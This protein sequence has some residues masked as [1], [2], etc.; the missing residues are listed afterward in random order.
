MNNNTHFSEIVLE[1]TLSAVRIERR[2]ETRQRTGFIVCLLVAGMVS[3][4]R[5][6]SREES[7]GVART[8]RDEVQTKTPAVIVFNTASAEATTIIST[9]STRD[10][11]TEIIFIDT[12][13]LHEMLAGITHGIYTTENGKTHFWSPLL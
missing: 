10:V 5:P 8:M 3:L 6:A 9:F 12:A 7:D 2:R 1:E 13:E 4:F 11:A